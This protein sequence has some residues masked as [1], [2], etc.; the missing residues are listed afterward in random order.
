M[1]LLPELQPNLYV[2]FKIGVYVIEEN[3]Y[4]AFSF[5]YMFLFKKSFSPIVLTRYFVVSVKNLS[6]VMFSFGMSV[7]IEV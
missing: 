1:E 7:D 5:V 4:V 6:Y 2:R 3:R